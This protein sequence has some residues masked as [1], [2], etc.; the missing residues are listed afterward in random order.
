MSRNLASVF[1][2]IAATIAAIGCGRRI[3]GFERDAP[4][5]A[6]DA[7]DAVV[8][9]GDAE[10]PD[11]GDA[12]VPD[13]GDGQ[14]ADAGDAE[15][16]DGG[17]ATVPPCGDGVLD[18][19]EDCDPPGSTQPCTSTCNTTGT[20]ECL[21][22]CTWAVDCTPPAEV[23]NGIDDNCDGLIDE[24]LYDVVGTDIRVTTAM[25]DSIAPAQIWTGTQFSLVW[26]DERV[27]DGLYFNAIDS[28]GA[29][30]LGDTQLTSVGG[31][32][33]AP[34]VDHTATGTAVV[35][36]ASGDAYFARS[37]STGTLQTAPVV[38][39]TTAGSSR[40]AVASTGTGQHGVA[41]SDTRNGDLEIY[42]SL[43]DDAG[44]ALVSDVRVT[45]ATGNS[46]HPSLT[47]TGSEF[48]LAWMDAR[49][50]YFEV[51]FARLDA[52][53]VKQGTDV[54]VTN[55]QTLSASPS[56]A[57]NGTD[58]GLAWVDFQTPP[59]I[60]FKRLDTQGNPL[61]PDIHVS[62]AFPGCWGT[63]TL[64][65]SGDFFGLVWEDLRDGDYDIFFTRL[66][67]DGTKLDQDIW[68]ST[69]ILDSQ[70]PYISW[71]GSLFG[72]AWT[73]ERDG[74]AAGADEI[75]FARVGCP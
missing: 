10:V 32:P 24:G 69:A 68:V 17:D 49:H 58:Y 50:G 16:P 19:G 53:G 67:A 1:F 72:V 3:V 29:I 21:W 33:Y 5:A 8:D 41:W 12:E 59:G 28:A 40:P 15:V 43:L 44:T 35:W 75:Y 34:H 18:P 9:A 52:N 11:A 2:L 51:Y 39:S 71:S 38:V 63:R 56:V 20:R 42:F 6:I 60:Y 14:V 37:N 4:D 46:I 66:T 73:D 27:P 36:E 54:R 64:T 13:A 74:V 70:C 23:C 65:W 26:S 7:G 62:M 47:Y 61:S 55:S 25:G 22:N 57:Y 31:E 48:G 30:L 45:D